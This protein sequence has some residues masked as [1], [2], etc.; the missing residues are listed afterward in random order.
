MDNRINE[1]RPKISALRGAMSHVEG[2][3]RD[4]INHDLDCTESSLRLMSMRT[5]LASLVAALTAA[6]GVEPLPTITERLKVNQRPAEKHKTP[7]RR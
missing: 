7:T 4:Q 3:I 5:K 6:G 1:I 2:T